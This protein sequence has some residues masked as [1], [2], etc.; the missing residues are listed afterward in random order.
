M[1]AGH[2]VVFNMTIRNVGPSVAR[3]V[4]VR[5]PLDERLAFRSA[6]PDSCGYQDRVL[7]CRFERLGP[8]ESVTVEWRGRV[9]PDTPDG[10][11]LRNV[12]KVSGMTPESRLD[13]NRG[14][15]EIIV[16]NR[17][18]GPPPH[19]PA[20][21]AEPIPGPREEL[22]FTGFPAWPLGL[23][24]LLVGVG[25]AVRWMARRRGVS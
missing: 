24:G 3:E 21:V 9:D 12:A 15:A 17:H 2:E 6:S 7:T 23:A 14:R 13:N 11:R 10:Y 8:E 1:R 5:D 19:G 22:P 4:V 16:T 25:S 18:A 20:P